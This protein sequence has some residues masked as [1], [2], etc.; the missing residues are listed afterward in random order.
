MSELCAQSG[1]SP[2]AAFSVRLAS[3]TAG[4][5]IGAA[6]ASV[7]FRLAGQQF[8]AVAALSAVPAALALALTGWFF[9]H[10]AA[11]GQAR[12]EGPVA[13]PAGGP[14]GRARAALAALPPAYWQALAVVAVLYLARFDFAFGVLR[15]R[16][17]LDPTRLP[18][19]LPL[20][21]LPQLLLAVPAG[22]AAKGGARARNGVL[23]AGMAVLIAADLAFA[24]V[25]TVPGIIAGALGIG[26]HMAATHGVSLGLLASCIPTEAIP[27]V[28]K[29]SGTAWSLTDLLL[30]E[31]GVTWPSASQ[32]VWQCCRWRWWRGLQRQRLTWDQAP[33]PR[34]ATPTPGTG[35]SPRFPQD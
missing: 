4:G 18:L 10:M 24:F 33:P 20:V 7:G 19:L 23:L 28:G 6:A 17:V 15:A 3:A 21:A 8:S 16:Q 12:R 13:P 27:G 25:P 26:I 1:D 32:R 34:A 9:G 22:S 2:T 29:I 30:G 14:V 11:A 35:T 5:L 31:P